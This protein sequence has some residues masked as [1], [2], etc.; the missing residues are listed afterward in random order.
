MASRIREDGPEIDAEESDT[1][2]RLQQWTKRALHRA[3][4]LRKYWGQP[5]GIGNPRFTFAQKQTEN[6]VSTASTAVIC[7][8]STATALGGPFGQGSID[9]TDGFRPLEVSWVRG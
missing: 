4:I 9:A 3:P 7:R 2:R 5:A 1:T 8:A 6:L